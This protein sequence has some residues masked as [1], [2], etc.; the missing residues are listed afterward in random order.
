MIEPDKQQEI[1]K[2]RRQSTIWTWILVGGVV[3][4][5]FGFLS[6][7][8]VR[9]TE[10][11]VTR[12]D[13]SSPADRPKDRGPAVRT[14][15]ERSATK[16]WHQ[17]ANWSGT[18]DKQTEAFKVPG[19]D[20]KVVWDYAGG[21]TVPFFMMSA[22]RLDEPDHLPIADVE[23]RNRDSSFLHTPGEYSLRIATN[24]RP[25]SVSVFARY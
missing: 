24:S 22:T 2:L 7:S 18:G 1:K 12:Q 6:K 5:L 15:A 10:Q 11:Q 23:G 17:V 19:R 21:G 4:T 9:K 8:S 16:S 13:F 20:W 14:Q 25:W 3:L